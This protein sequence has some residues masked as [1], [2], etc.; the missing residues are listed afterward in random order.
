VYVYRP[1]VRNSFGLA[2]YGRD[3]RGW[4][5]TVRHTGRKHVDIEVNASGT[6]R[7]AADLKEKRAARFGAPP[8]SMSGTVQITLH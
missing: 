1:G 6:A 8:A 5:V 2:S 4:Y 7:A 3:S